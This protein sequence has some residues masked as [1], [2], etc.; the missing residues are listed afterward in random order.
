MLTD[1]YAIIVD[2]TNNTHANSCRSID[3]DTVEDLLIFD[4]DNSDSDKVVQR[5]ESGRFH[6]TRNVR[7]SSVNDGSTVENIPVEIS[8]DVEINVSSNPIETNSAETIFMPL[9]TDKPYKIFQYL[10]SEIING[11]NTNTL[12]QT[13]SRIRIYYPR[14]ETYYDITIF[15]FNLDDFQ[16]QIFTKYYRYNM[17]LFTKLLLK[18]YIQLSLIEPHDLLLKSNLPDIV[19]LKILQYIHE[20]TLTTPP[21]SN[22]SVSSSMFEQVLV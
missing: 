6:I 13:I 19:L 11:I 1:D 20:P 22:I 9:V 8:V 21:S 12:A 16:Q 2:K 4:S 17:K 3:N 10:I 14:M 15:E 5:S 7:R 18:H